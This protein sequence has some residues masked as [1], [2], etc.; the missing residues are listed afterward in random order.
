M[1]VDLAKTAVEDL[2]NIIR[3]Y[4]SQSV[5]KVGQRLLAEIIAKIERL[6]HYPDSGRVA[7]EFGVEFIREIIFSP[8]RIVYQRKSERIWV[9]RV[10]RSERSLKDFPP[11]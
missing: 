2:E 7:P 5:P 1:R 8:F 4:E 6:K 9:I 11:P 3:Y 10:W